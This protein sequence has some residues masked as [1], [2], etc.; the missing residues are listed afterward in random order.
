MNDV[1]F[2]AQIALVILVFV[3]L[4]IYLD[5]VYRNRQ[6]IYLSTNSLLKPYRLIELSKG[7]K[8]LSLVFCWGLFILGFAV[9]ALILLDY[10]IRFFDQ[11]YTDKFNEYLFNSF[12]LAVIGVFFVMLFSIILGYY[13]R[14]K[15]HFKINN[16]LI[17]FVV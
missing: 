10:S 9:P 7:Q 11:A 2:A 13:S 4:L 3:F 8:I 12:S 15:K 14:R 6:K 17:S 16:F 5:K 1:G